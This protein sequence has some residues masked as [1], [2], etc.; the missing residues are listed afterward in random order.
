[1]IALPCP[2][3]GADLCSSVLQ[4]L[5][6]AAGGKLQEDFQGVVGVAARH[7]QAAGTALCSQRLQAQ[8]ETKLQQTQKEQKECLA[9]RLPCRPR[10]LHLPHVQAGADPA[11]RGHPQSFA[12]GG[13]GVPLAAG[14]QQD[15]QLAVP[16]A[17]S[18]ALAVDVCTLE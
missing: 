14:H 13:R 12:Y 2:L 7:G 17:T 6:G 10:L 9:D 18:Q 5:P 16:R 15:H 11:G 8:G 3:A 1:M 4:K